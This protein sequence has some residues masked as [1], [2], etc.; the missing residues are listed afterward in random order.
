VA[1]QPPVDVRCG[2]LRDEAE[3][4]RIAAGAVADVVL[5]LA[6][7]LAD[8]DDAGPE[9]TACV[10]AVWRLGLTG[11]ELSDTMAALA[12]ALDGTADGV[13]HVV[14]RLRALP[15]AAHRHDAVAE[16]L[17]ALRSVCTSVHEGR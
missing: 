4:W 6:A 3:R 5:R 14:T 10:L 2:D 11:G 17:R 15:L 16:L 13:D 1:N 9:A 8:L 7:P 12:G